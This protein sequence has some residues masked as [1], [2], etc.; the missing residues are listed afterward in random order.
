MAWCVPPAGLWTTRPPGPGSGASISAAMS[1]PPAAVAG[2]RQT[3][4][5]TGFDGV[6]S[7]KRSRVARSTAPSSSARRSASR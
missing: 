7:P 5:N 3:S 6:P 4:A 1:E 2:R